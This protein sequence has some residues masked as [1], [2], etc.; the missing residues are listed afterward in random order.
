MNERFMQITFV[1]INILW[2]ITL[3]AVMFAREDIRVARQEIR[4]QE[5]F[6]RERI[7]Y[8]DSVSNALLREIQNNQM[9]NTALIEVMSDWSKVLL[10]R[11]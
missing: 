3:G 5:E 9:H 1:I 10:D 2:V 4:I 6:I 11:E 8:Y 7:A